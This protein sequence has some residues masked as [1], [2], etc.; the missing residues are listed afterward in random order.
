MGDRLEV[1]AAL[2]HREDYL[3]YVFGHRLGYQ[4][5]NRQSL[6]L[7]GVRDKLLS[8]G[9]VMGSKSLPTQISI[10]DRLEVG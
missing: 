10:S 1:T 5:H 7:G 3:M 8:I 4:E 6:T 2:Y 9:R